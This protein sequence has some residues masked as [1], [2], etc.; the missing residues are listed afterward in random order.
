MSS[1]R[2]AEEEL[3]DWD[4]YLE[5][6]QLRAAA[7]GGNDRQEAEDKIS[8]L[9]GRRNLLNQRLGEVS[10]AHTELRESRQRVQAARDDLERRAALVQAWFD[11][12]GEA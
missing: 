9:R 3:H 5:R 2:D 7:T 4:V 10:S 11:Q 6:L 1:L 8:E 12:R